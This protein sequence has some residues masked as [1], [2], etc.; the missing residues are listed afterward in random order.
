LVVGSATVPTGRYGH[1]FL[2]PAGTVARPAFNSNFSSVG[3]KPPLAPLPG[4]SFVIPAEVETRIDTF[5]LYSPIPWLAFIYGN[6]LQKY[7]NS[8]ADDYAY[9]DHGYMSVVPGDAIGRRARY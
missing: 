8:K 4:F 5:L 7:K 2:T 9:H 3:S 1:D 6:L